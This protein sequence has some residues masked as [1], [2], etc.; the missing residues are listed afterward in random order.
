MIDFT[1]KQQDLSEKTKS[2]EKDIELLQLKL[3]DT[4]NQQQ[5]AIEKE[6]YDEADALNIR[7]TQTKN[8][9]MSKENQIKRLDEDY[10][11]LENKKGDKYKELSVLIHK[12]LTKMA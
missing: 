10:M 2:L 6:D 7:I 3:E 1:M 9:I 11:T 12:S 8:L 4:A 5:R